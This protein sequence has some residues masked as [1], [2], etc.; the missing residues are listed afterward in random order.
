MSG[1]EA[2]SKA[3]NHDINLSLTCPEKRLEEMLFRKKLTKTFYYSDI[4]FSI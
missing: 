1:G 2:G 4:S 3:K